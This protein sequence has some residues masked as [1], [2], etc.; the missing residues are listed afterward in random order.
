MSHELVA[1]LD[2][3]D[4]SETIKYLIYQAVVWTQFLVG[5]LDEALRNAK[6]QRQLEAAGDP[7]TRAFSIATVGLIEIVS[8]DHLQ[9]RARLR[10]AT[11]YIRVSTDAVNQAQIASYWAS[12]DGDRI[13]SRRRFRS[14]C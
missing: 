3:M 13:R 12:L 14:P 10:E 9:G 6:R 1:I 4:G 7:H 2:R 5:S 8:G 11:E